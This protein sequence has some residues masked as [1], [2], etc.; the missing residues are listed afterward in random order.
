MTWSLTSDTLHMSGRGVPILTFLLKRFHLD[1]SYAVCY[2][3][4]P[5]GIHIC[6]ALTCLTAKKRNLTESELHLQETEP[7]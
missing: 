5:I 7:N 1:Q 2:S 6:T 3:S 4:P